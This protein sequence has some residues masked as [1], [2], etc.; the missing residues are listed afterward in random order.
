M[1]ESYIN[2]EILYCVRVK[3]KFFENNT[4]P[5]SYF[6]LHVSA[7]EMCLVV[8]LSQNGWRIW[9]GKKTLRVITSKYMRL[10]GLT[11][12]NDQDQYAHRDTRRPSSMN[13]WDRLGSAVHGI[14]F[15][16]EDKLE[17]A[18]ETND[19][20]WKFLAIVVDRVLL[21]IHVLLVVFNVGW[22]AW[23]LF[24][25]ESLTYDA[26]TYLKK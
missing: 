15:Q 20:R 3:Y 7:S 25:V 21:I 13:P 6:F 12:L 8:N 22:L 10:I 17:Q 24:N 1:P 19:I 14:K 2:S 4:K 23:R 16:N 26:P 18:K 5:V 9:M 11:P